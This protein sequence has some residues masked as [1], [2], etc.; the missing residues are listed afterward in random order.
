M[1]NVKT[2]R[3][4]IVG[5]GVV[6][7]TS[8][9]YLAK[10]GYDVTVVDKAE[11]SGMA[12]SFANGGQL[13]YSHVDPLA[14]PSLFSKLPKMALGLDPAF[15]MKLSTDPDFIKWVMMF[16][17]NCTKEKDFHSTERVLHLA[18]HSHDKLADLR[19][20]VELDFSFRQN[21]KL[22]CY[23]TADDENAI[24]EKLSFKRKHGANQWLLPHSECV[25]L[26]PSLAGMPELAFGV[27]AE[28][29]EAGDA[30]QFSQALETYCES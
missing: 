5:S 16:L 7:V 17:R 9:Y 29:D 18:L 1:N 11:K 27:Y 21:G 6:G 10:L 25:N 28:G 14:T 22:I 26:E 24:Q 8:A 15:S 19:Q 3:I 20:E 30:L 23:S 13:S 4:V 2:Q 12:T